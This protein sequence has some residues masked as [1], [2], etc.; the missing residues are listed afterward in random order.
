MT[1]ALR[2]YLVAQ[3]ALP[4][5]VRQKLADPNIETRLAAIGI[6]SEAG[7]LDDVA[8]FSDLLSLPPSP[9]EDPRERKELLH[10]MWAIANRE[11]S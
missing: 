5:G 2:S 9:D 4:D 3:R 11:R 8:L 7:T 10:G 1:D 6:V